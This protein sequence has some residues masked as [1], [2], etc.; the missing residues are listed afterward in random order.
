MYK[1]S[2]D[3]SPSKKQPLNHSSSLCNISSNLYFCHFKN[4]MYMGGVKAFQRNGRGL[5]LHDN[6]T[7]VISSYYNDLLH[8]HNV[9]FTNSCLLSAEFNKNKLVEGVYRTDGILLAV[10]YNNDG[11]LDGKIVLLNY[12]TKG[13][14]VCVFKKGVMVEKKEET[15]FTVINRIFDLG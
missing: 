9:F 10:S 14:M 6:G 15:D 3:K 8:G 2:S 5:L 7:N 13:I 1:K 4:A 12:V 11:Q